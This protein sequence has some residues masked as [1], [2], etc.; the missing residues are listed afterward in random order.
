MPPTENPSGAWDRADYVRAYD[1]MKTRCELA[2]AGLRTSIHTRMQECH[3][4][5]NVLAAS[6]A[7]V[8][9]LRDALE[10]I[11]KNRANRYESTVGIMANIA[12]EALAK[13]GEA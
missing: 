7:E 5:A 12:D 10:S 4:A 2:E 13:G 3:E 11:L 6:R 1:G 9:R 8:E